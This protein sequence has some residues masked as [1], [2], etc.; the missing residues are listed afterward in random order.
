MTGKNSLLL[1]VLFSY[2]FITVTSSGLSQDDLSLNRAGYFGTTGLDVFV[3]TDNYPEGHQGGIQIIQHGVRIAANGDLWL[4]P[5]P[6]QWSPFS[7]VNEKQIDTADQSII[8]SL[9][10]PNQQAAERKFNP[11]TY[12]D[13]EFSY[14]I[15]VRAESNAFRIVV[16]LDEPLPKE[17][18]GRVG[19]NLELFPGSLFEKKYFMG[20]K[21]G[22]F[23]RQLNGPYYQTSDKI[24]EVIPMAEG[25]ELVIAPGSDRQML[26]IKSEKGSI[27]LIDG[28]SRHNNGWFIARSLVPKN[29]TTGAIE[30][31]IIPKII[32]NWR[33]SPVIHVNQVGYLPNQSKI[34]LLECD[35]MDSLTGPLELVRI[36]PSGIQENVLTDPAKLWGTYQRYKY[37]QFDFT[38]I[39]EP[40]IYFL[41]YD[42]IRSEY[43]R[44]GEDIFDR[45]VW[46]PTLEYFLPVQMCHM[47][48]NDR[49]KVWHG[50]CHMDDARMAPV[51]H[52]HFDGYYQGPSTHSSF[53]PGEHVPGLNTGGW[54]D[55]GDYDLRV[56]SQ[57]GTVYVL[58]L[59]YE[60]FHPDYDISTIDQKNH[61]VEMHQPDGKPDI[62]QQI[63]HG[64]L[65]IVNGYNVLGST[66]RG[67]ICSDL[68]Q[69]VILG[70][71][72][73]MT[74]N[75]VYS[76]DKNEGIPEWFRGKND[77]RL[78]FT[79][80]NPRRNFQ[81][82]AY[83]A[84]AS[85]TLK[86][87]NDTLAR[88][89]LKIA[90]DL[91]KLNLEE[92]Y[93]VEK[94]LA[95][96]ELVL[97]TDRDEYLNQLVSMQGEVASHVPETGWAIA[98]ILDRIDDPMFQR[99]YML[100]IQQYYMKLRN[101]TIENP[102]GV[103][104]KPRIWG[105]AWGIERFGVEQYY[106]HSILKIEDAKQYMLNA[107][108]YVLGV[109][110]GENTASFVSG[111][112]THSATVAYG[113]NRDDWS[114]IPGGVISGTAYIKP[115][116]P[117]LKEWP[118]LWQQ[119]EYMISGAG[120]S[121]MFLVLGA[122]KILQD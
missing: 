52:V 3:F 33:Y 25:K 56:E 6:G 82:I 11:I 102:F 109:H 15:E 28:R 13:L 73:V 83:L 105:L 14:T 51:N 99:G 112:G 58:S 57:G 66:Y 35:K 42:T 79:E 118:Y 59:I 76:E 91:W 44:I 49:Y 60:A 27:Q 110:P 121:F 87:F 39:T 77:D 70:D 18:I 119:T 53:Q 24:F 89:S 97:S 84:A 120:E 55:A 86:G 98:R 65:N 88:Q 21:A 7:Q 30:W 17:W 71:G 36:L 48:V 94:I 43:F 78:V 68:R 34:A 72:S 1:P 2:F 29:V 5:A 4:E 67:I 54:H 101:E 114:Y 62:L 64:T 46:Q 40:G 122:A 10:Y 20:G 45:N 12:P 90:E 80:H 104:Y 37:Y 41:A 85:R 96:V 23:P 8:V 26:T 50:L 115:D 9:S 113:L 63:E 31:L 75:I 69:Y 108:N 81:T 100:G 19:F 95:L 107:L 117:E 111:V 32:D 116:F 93:A 106:L 103:P 22:S 47:R 92:E 61:I 74:D 38:R 16:N